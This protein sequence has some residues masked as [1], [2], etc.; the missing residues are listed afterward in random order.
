ME[1]G[2]FACRSVWSSRFKDESGLTNTEGEVEVEVEAEA[3]IE[4]CMLL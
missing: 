2:I 3:L 4:V 1:F